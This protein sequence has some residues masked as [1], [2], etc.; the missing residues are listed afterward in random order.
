MHVRDIN[1]YCD[2]ELNYMTS[3][4]HQYI[5]KFQ[6]LHELRS[7]PATRSIHISQ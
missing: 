3:E 7:L 4:H 1:T 6:T 5:Q 2:L